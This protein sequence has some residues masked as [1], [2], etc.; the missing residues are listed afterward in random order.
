[1]PKMKKWL[2]GTAIM[3]GLVYAGAATVYAA[4]LANGG[5]PFP[6]HMDLTGKIGLTMMSVGSVGEFV[7]TVILAWPEFRFKSK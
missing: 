3:G 5:D 2:V 1:M 7:W 6:P 4:S